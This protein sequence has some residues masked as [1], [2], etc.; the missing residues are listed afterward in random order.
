[1]KKFGACLQ[2]AGCCGLY[3]VLLSKR[4]ETVYT[5]EPAA[6]EFSALALNCQSRKIVKAQMALGENPGLVESFIPESAGP[7]LSSGEHQVKTGG[8][9][10]DHDR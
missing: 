3:P 7:G 1:M 5:F 4:F 6:Y 2:A 9:A 10:N 8:H